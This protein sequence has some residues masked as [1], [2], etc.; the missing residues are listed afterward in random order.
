[1]KL[2]DWSASNRP[3]E[4]LIAYGVSAL[5]DAELL[6]LILQQGTRDDNVITISNRLLMDGMHHLST[7]SLTELQQI[8]GIGPAKAMQIKVPL[9]HLLSNIACYW[10]RSF[11]HGFAFFENS[12][13]VTL[14]ARI[15]A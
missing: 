11:L 10:A 8:K 9:S 2:K 5:S 13:A 4:R 7:R 3:R 12:E 6:A 14:H 15:Q 1:M